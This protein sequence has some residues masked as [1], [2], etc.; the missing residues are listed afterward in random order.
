MNELREAVGQLLIGGFPGSEI[1]QH[2]AELAR[3]G[4]VGGAIV[5]HRNLRDVE[6]AAHLARG[7]LALP[8]PE[9]LFLAI[10]QEGGRVQRLWD[11]FPEM[12]P[13]RALGDTRKKT[14]AHRAGYLVGDA[15]ALVGFQQNYAPVLDVD[16][17]PDNPVIGDRA[18]SSDPAVVA[19]LGSSYIEGLQSSGVAACGKHFPGHGDT[20][21]DSHL[22]LPSLSH[23]RERLDAI[24][25]VPFRA[26]VRTGVAAIMTAHI[27][28]PE[29]D[30]EH[31]AT[32]SERVIH[33][34]LR[35]ELGYDGVVVSDD[36]EMR[37]IADHYGVPDAAVR[38]IRA[39]CDQ[40]L[41]CHHPE[42]IAESHAAIVAAV[43]K[44]TLDRAR[45]MEAAARVRKLKA[46]YRPRADLP[47]PSAVAAL[48]AKDEHR[49]LL[50][51]ISGAVE[52]API[53]ARED[54]PIV[55]YDLGEEASAPLALDLDPTESWRKA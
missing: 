9:P 19:R 31:P 33:A 54:L 12:P 4:L 51:E 45:V 26:A 53:V 14:L 27:M 23:N 15:L 11:P 20:L 30:P 13:M 29:L 46:E 36:L 42:L 55:E 18:F 7:L 16:S 3:D 8:A 17:N 28:F 52:A 40:L 32:L 44:G 21:E 48:F 49:K 10:D 37:A 22:S 34:L 6:Q 25:L 2:F 1:H 43:E 39:G 35:D 41:I 5:F 24:E 50:A 38:S 47:E